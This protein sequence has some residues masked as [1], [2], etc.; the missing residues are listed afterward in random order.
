MARS[1]PALALAAA[2]AHASVAAA[3]VY[4]IHG[5]ALWHRRRG[6]G[7]SERSRTTRCCCVGRA[8]GRRWQSAGQHGQP[9]SRRGARSLSA[10]AWARRAGASKR[11]IISAGAWRLLMAALNVAAVLWRVLC[12]PRRAWVRPLRRCG[13]GMGG[14]GSGGARM[15]CASMPG[16]MAA[17]CSGI[18]DGRSLRAP[19]NAHRGRRGVAWSADGGLQTIGGG[20][21]GSA[22]AAAPTLRLLATRSAILPRDQVALLA[23]SD[24][25]D[26]ATVACG[27]R[28]NGQR[29]RGADGARWPPWARLEA[30]LARA[31]G[32]TWGARRR[33]GR[34]GR[35]RRWE[36]VLVHVCI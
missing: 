12:K 15:S 6:P 30:P 19:H 8:R 5:N 28:G 36:D 16:A 26:L 20:S 18:E 33:D 9:S 31:L 21:G 2:A 17:A 35:G 27:P 23:F 24:F 3:I 34:H 11:A 4:N 22:S 32:C 10:V 14:C 1:S 25:S 29:G 7:P 13:H